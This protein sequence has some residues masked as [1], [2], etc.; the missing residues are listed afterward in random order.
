MSVL[1]FA[2]CAV[3]DYLIFLYLEVDISV[4]SSFLPPTLFLISVYPCYD[5]GMEL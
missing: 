4:A 5:S 1:S 3:L 2:E